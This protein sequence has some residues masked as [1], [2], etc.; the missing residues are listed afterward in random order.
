MG[1]GMVPRS[2]PLAQEHPPVR[3]GDCLEALDD[4]MRRVASIVDQ[5]LCNG[6]S[7]LDTSGRMATPRACV[8]RCARSL[9][10]RQ[11]DFTGTLACVGLDGRLMSRQ[12]PL[13]P[14]N[15]SVQSRAR[16]SAVREGG[17]PVQNDSGDAEV[18]AL[19]CRVRSRDVARDIG[20][21]GAFKG[22]DAG[23]DA[24]APGY[25]GWW[26]GVLGWV[27]LWW[28]GSYWRRVRLPR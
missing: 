9:G 1:R 2:C 25:S 26:P 5:F 21:D 28:R 7:D 22:S 19:G 17:G 23:G 20:E 16:T 10:E 3:S 27:E 11:R 8:R 4:A 14:R 24:G 13:G 6:G 12:R 15:A 18:A